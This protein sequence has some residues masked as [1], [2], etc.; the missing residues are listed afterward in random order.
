MSVPFPPEAREAGL[1]AA[2]LLPPPLLLLLLLLV[3]LRLGAEAGAQVVQRT[4]DGV[5]ILLPLLGK[6]LVELKGK[7]LGSPLHC[8]LHGRRV[9]LLMFD[10]TPPP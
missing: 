1:L 5:P 6:S 2:L 3:L 9:W 10:Q 7:V 4:L 8:A